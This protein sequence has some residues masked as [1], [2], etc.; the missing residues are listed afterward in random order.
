MKPQKTPPKGTGGYGPMLVLKTGKK[1]KKT[2]EKIVQV[3][4]AGNNPTYMFLALTSAGR[5]LE[6]RTFANI[7]LD[8]EDVTP[9]LNLIKPKK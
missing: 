2:K 1:P 5:V 6:R 9:D 7:I 3:A 8:W 4:I